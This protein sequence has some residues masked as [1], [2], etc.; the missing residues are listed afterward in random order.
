[1]SNNNETINSIINK[2]E[3]FSILNIVVS[4]ILFL[5]LEPYNYKEIFG[6]IKEILN[7]IVIIYLILELFKIFIKYLC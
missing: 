7:I 6:G 4:I 2:I 5:I 3:Y 1:M